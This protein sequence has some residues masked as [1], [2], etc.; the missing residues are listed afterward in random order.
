MAKKIEADPVPILIGR[1]GLSPHDDEFVRDYPT[2][3]QLLMPRYADG[4]V[5]TREPG[6]VS[7]KI[8]GSLYRVTLV[9]P[10]ERCQTTVGLTTLC[11][12]LLDLECHVSDPKSDW[13]P[14][15]DSKKKARR[16]LDKSQ[17]ALY[18]PE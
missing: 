4:C 6:I 16:Q 9:C 18:N 14:T 7:I 8:D 12:L 11:N 13:V 1:V 3:A 2:L 10:T 5:M 15:W 17:D